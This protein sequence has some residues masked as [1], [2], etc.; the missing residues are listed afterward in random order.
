MSYL[1]Y[2]GSQITGPIDYLHAKNTTF[3]T[4]QNLTFSNGILHAPVVETSALIT[5]SDETFKENINNLNNTLEKLLEL[6]GKIYNYKEESELHFGYIAQD[7]KEIFPHIVKQDNDKLFI[8]YIE[9]IPIIT[10]SIKE[11]FQMIKTFEKKINEM[12]NL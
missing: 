6:Q 9:L 7:V 12:N 10:E 1:L 4:E 3:Y 11:L 8:A 5:K 2:T